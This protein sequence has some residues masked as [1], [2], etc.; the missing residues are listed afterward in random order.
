MTAQFFRR[1][2]S[3]F[4]PS[5]AAKLTVRLSYSEQSFPAVARRHSAQLSMLRNIRKT[6]SVC[7]QRRN[8]EMTRTQTVHK[9]KKK[10]I[11]I[12]GPDLAP[13]T[14]MAKCCTLLIHSQE[15]TFVAP[16]VFSCWFAVQFTCHS[17]SCMIIVG[18][19]PEINLVG[20]TV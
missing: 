2:R 10:K 11:Q 1:L 5:P 18:H 12:M 8:C 9:K 20:L 6:C 19:V 15:N 14:D 7:V 3:T 16:S 17:S 4:T 13:P